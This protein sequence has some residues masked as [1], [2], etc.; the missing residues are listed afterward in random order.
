MSRHL[1]CSPMQMNYCFVLVKIKRKQKHHQVKKHK[2]FSGYTAKVKQS[3]LLWERCIGT[4]GYMNFS[5]TNK[6]GGTYQVVIRDDTHKTS[7]KIAQF[8]RAPTSLVHL[9]PKFFQLLDLVN[10]PPLPS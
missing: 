3:N 1:S 4:S 7:M 5:V 8:S 2:G 10:E 9:R 6:R